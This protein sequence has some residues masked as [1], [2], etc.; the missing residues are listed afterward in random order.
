MKTTAFR[1]THPVDYT[2]GGH[3]DGAWGGDELDGTLQS[4]GEGG[5]QFAKIIRGDQIV[6]QWMDEHRK[7]MRYLRLM[8][9]KIWFHLGSS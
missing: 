5:E 2:G 7:S 3:V 4:D 9:N 8:D 6:L 1:A